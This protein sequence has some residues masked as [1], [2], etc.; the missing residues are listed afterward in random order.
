MASGGVILSVAALIGAVRL[1]TGK[2]DGRAILNMWAWAELTYLLFSI[3]YSVVSLRGI[4]NA[5]N[6]HTLQI[7]SIIG[8]VMRTTLADG[9]LPLVVLV[10]LRRSVMENIAAG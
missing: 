8:G 7:V 9:I 10:L 3:V 5:G 1:W 6:I 2:S 4:G